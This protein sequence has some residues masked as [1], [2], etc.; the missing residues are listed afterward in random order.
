MPR[1]K[2]TTGKGKGGGPPTK[3]RGKQ[4][5]KPPTPPPTEENVSS[6]SDVNEADEVVA[7]I[8]VDDAQIAVGL[9]VTQE[10]EASQATQKTEKKPRG[11][12]S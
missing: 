8:P 3:S 12:S 1:R 2:G 5:V 4:V 7:V 6:D 11:F 9:H 10:D